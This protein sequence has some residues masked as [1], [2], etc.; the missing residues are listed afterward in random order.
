LQIET[1]VQKDAQAIFENALRINK[2]WANWEILYD[3]VLGG[4]R[5]YYCVR[6]LNF[7]QLQEHTVHKYAMVKLRFVTTCPSQK[8][9][10]VPTI[11][12]R[13]LFYPACQTL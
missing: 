2:V 3:S 11:Y 7:L 10:L 4:F 8:I 6:F 5:V 1:E 12:S 13:S 9:S